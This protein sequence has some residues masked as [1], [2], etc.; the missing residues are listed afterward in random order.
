MVDRVV[1]I[2]DI[3]VARKHIEMQLNDLRLRLEGDQDANRY[4]F[5]RDC[6]PDVLLLVK[7]SIET[8]N[9][10]ADI[11]M[12]CTQVVKRLFKE[13]R[14]ML[15]A[16]LDFLDSIQMDGLLGTL[17]RALIDNHLNLGERLRYAGV[18]DVLIASDVQ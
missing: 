14:P 13:D 15:R 4:Y 9:N 18:E 16:S 3:T 12:G 10:F 17:C 7:K 6:D 11:N 2:L 8:P 5:N 1:G